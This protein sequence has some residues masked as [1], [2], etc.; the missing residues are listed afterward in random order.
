[1]PQEP[2]I[3]ATEEV[4]P[5]V[6]HL[7]FD[8]ANCDTAQCLKRTLRLFL[9]QAPGHRIVSVAPIGVYGSPTARVIVTVPTVP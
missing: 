7:D 4:S 6:F 5:G 3:T 8:G 9:E 1:E 2:E